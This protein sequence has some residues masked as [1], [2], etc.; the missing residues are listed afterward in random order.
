M[1]KTLSQLPPIRGRW[2]TASFHHPSG[3]IRIQARRGSFSMFVPLVSACDSLDGRDVTRGISNIRLRKEGKSSVLTFTE[4]SELWDR[5][6][7]TV[8]FGPDIIRYKYKVF[9]E[10]SVGRAYFFRSWFENDNTV[11]RELGTIP[12]FDTVFNPAVNF[13]GKDYYFSGD[14][15]VMTSGDCKKFWGQGLVSAPYCYGLNDRGDDLWVGAGIGV[16]PGQYTFEEFNYNSNVTNRIYGASG[17]DCNYNGKLHVDGSWESPTMLLFAADDEY[18][19]LQ[20]YVDILKKDYKL[21]LDA[22]KSQPTWWRTPIFCGWGEQMSLAFA[23][24]G[25][26]EGVNNDEYCTQALHDEW[27]DTLAA[28][29]IRAGQV[30]ID[31]GW[32]R[33]GTRGDM[34]VDEQRWPDLRGW[35]EDQQKSGVRVLLWMLA[36]NRQGVPDEEC[37]TDADGKA[38]NV[39]PTNPA[40]E[41]RL[42]AMIR[43]MLSDEPGC[44]NADGLKIDGELGCPQGPGLKNHKNVWGLELQRQ[45]LSIVRDEARKHKPEAV[46]GLYMANPYLADMTDVARTA[47]QFSNRPDPTHTMIHRAKVLAIANPGRPIDTDHAYYYDVRENWADIM[48]E[49]VN[50]PGGIPCLYH[51][52]LVWHKH[53]FM[54]TYMEEMTDE[55]YAAVRKAFNRCWR[56]IKGS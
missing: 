43:R 39:D 2:Y 11:E 50:I 13:W 4:T 1:P 9:G 45:Y 41:K 37:V 22:P 49:Q 14:R 7:Y 15:A 8:E 54:P 10:G 48:A 16:R 19:M 5:K 32:E 35:I 31:A 29:K 33:A 47:D 36:W 28:K 44:Y 51:A 20:R 21:S 34:Y 56:A 42:R 53:P 25:N 18:S 12:G 3:Q 24:H 27:M 26:F 6:S 38:V 40:Y 30:I 46:M 23:D 17:F 52:K 55:H